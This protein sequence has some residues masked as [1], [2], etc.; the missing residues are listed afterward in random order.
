MKTTR[1]LPALVLLGLVAASLR[2]D[3]GPIA[4]VLSH[5]VSLELC[6]KLLVLVGAWLTGYGMGQWRNR[7]RAAPA[8]KT[9]AQPLVLR[10]VPGSSHRRASSA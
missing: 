3:W 7:Y 4:F 2:T 10:V 1:L 9:Q 5:G 6:G 8:R